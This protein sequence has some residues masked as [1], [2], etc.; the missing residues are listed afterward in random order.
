MPLTESQVEAA[1]IAYLQERGWAVTT[2]NVDY[3]DLI[4]TR[5]AELL[6]AELKGHTK[7]PETAIDIGYGQLLRR[8]KA[9]DES[10]RYALVVPETLMWHVERVNAAV[11]ARI[12]IE[13]FLIDDLGVV[14]QL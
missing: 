12:G 3:T 8:I 1:F 2:T 4:A 10:A 5:G 6:L 14:R 13:V 7:S 11:R 9:D